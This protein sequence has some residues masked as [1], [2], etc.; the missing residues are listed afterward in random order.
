[1]DGGGIRRYPFQ[2]GRFPGEGFGKIFEEKVRQLLVELSEH[3]E[4]A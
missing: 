1:M 4:K 2:R 3:G